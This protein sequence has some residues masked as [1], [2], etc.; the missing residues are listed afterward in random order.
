MTFT[1]TTSTLF[2]RDGL[3]AELADFLF[4]FTNP[5][6]VI[7]ALPQLFK[8]IKGQTIKGTVMQGAQIHG[9]VYIGEGTVVHSN[10]VIEGPVYVGRNVIVGPHSTLRKHTYIADDCVIGHGADI[11]NT[12][13]LNGAK[14]Q[15][16][17]F[18]GNSLLGQGARVAYGGILYN[19]KF[20]Q[21]NVKVDLGNGNIIESSRDFLGAIM[22]DE[23]RIGAN[24]VLSPGTILG[25]YTW[26]GSGL[27][28]HGTIP[29]NKL[30]TVKQDYEIRDKETVKL[31]SGRPSANDIL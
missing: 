10:A 20:N 9:D 19:R 14:I 15:I 16:N 31:K 8:N 6:D 5:V 4:S 25:P 13:A 2:Q 18:A 7:D 23:S 29:P 12:L 26:V 28:L 11:K 22:G 1:V 3:N 27:V 30:V 24:V 21:S 17:A